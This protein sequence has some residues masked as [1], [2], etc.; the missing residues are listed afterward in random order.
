M[1]SGKPRN[2]E[3]FDGE[4]VK[5]AEI[6]G[7][8]L[9]EILYSSNCERAAHVHEHACFHFLYQGGYTESYGRRTYECDTHTLAFQPKW[10][11]HSYRA[12]ETASRA[13]TIELEDGWL[14]RLDEHSIILDEACNLRSGLILWL[15]NRLYREFRQ[16]DTSSPLA[17]EAL[18]LEISVEASRRKL[19]VSRIGTPPFL[20]RARDFLN[21]QFAEPISLKAVAQAV[22]VHPV[23]LARVFRQR[24]GCT[25]GEYLR[26]L[27]IEYACRRMIDSD[28]TLLEI[29]MDAGF[30]DQSQFSHTF[31]REMGLSP[32]KFRADLQSR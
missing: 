7:L 11:Q 12:S 15:I 23:H 24:F 19:P 26:R 3:F 30:S 2:P 22:G 31:R 5:W 10:H 14:N 17:I 16:M 6:S 8:K 4:V 18:A 32:A 1:S 13:F 21:D 25:V 9:G 20:D 28:S 27:R 29:A